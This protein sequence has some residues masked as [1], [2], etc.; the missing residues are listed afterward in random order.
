[1]HINELHDLTEEIIARGQCTLKHEDALKL[2]NHETEDLMSAAS[3]IR[4]QV[5]GQTGFAC[6]IINAKSGRC[7]Q[8]CA[9]CA[10]SAHHDTGVEVYA[11]LDEETILKRAHLMQR[12]GA[13][14]FSMVTSGTEL[15]DSEIESVCQTTAR[16]L[17]ETGLSVCGSL[18]MLTEE[19]AERLA[20]S[21]MRRY[22][23]NLETPRSH[24]NQICTTHAYDD[25][26]ATIR[27]A[28]AAGMDC[29]CGC[30]FGLGESWEQRIEL[31]IELRELPVDCLPLNFLNPV[32]GTPMQDK[33]LLSP[34]E[35]LRCVALLRIL[36]PDKDITI[37]G[38]REVTLKD[39]QAGLITAGANALMIGNY[40]TTSGR[41]AA[42]DI[43]L[44]GEAGIEL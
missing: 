8:D 14:R 11:L 38:G 30:I 19:K 28:H 39:F 37:C 10:Q 6:A 42:M 43:E 17:R 20:Q 9:F 27:I 32:K 18:G 3:R 25:D 16:I 2:L 35:A 22:H 15:N 40:L 26:I 12:A 13:S 36:C 41:D 7:A 1:M 31:A 21:G 34:M 5:K 29:C 33:A 23:H 24:F 4:R 44:L